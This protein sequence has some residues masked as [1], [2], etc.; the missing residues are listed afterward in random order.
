MPITKNSGR[1]EPVVATVD[2]TFADIPTTAQINAALDMPQNAIVIGGDLTVTTVW[3]TATSAAL[4]VGD[5]TLGTRYVAAADL[6][7]LGRTALTLTGFTHTNVQK[8][9]TATPTYVGAAA[10]TGAARLTVTYIVKDR[11]LH[12]FGLGR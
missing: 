2:F 11:A 7:A 12:A 4:A 9:I 5:V 1:Q 6:K 3:N 10:T 8:E